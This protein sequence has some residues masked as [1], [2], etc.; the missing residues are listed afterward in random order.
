MVGGV[1]HQGGLPGQPVWVTHFGRVSFLHV[2][3]V[4]WGWTYLT[5]V[6]KSLK[7]GELFRRFQHQNSDEIDSAGDNF[8][9]GIG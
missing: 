5:G 9:R 8:K 1:P 3:A 7:Q 4:E 2:K 6:I